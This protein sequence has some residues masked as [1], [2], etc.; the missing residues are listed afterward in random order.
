MTS[1]QRR[2]QGPGQNVLINGAGVASERSPIQIA[3]GEVAE[4]IRCMQEE[5]VVGRIVVTPTR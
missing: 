1:L 2:P 3:K 5:T 4:A